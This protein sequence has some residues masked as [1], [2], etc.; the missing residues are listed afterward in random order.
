MRGKTTFHLNMFVWYITWNFVFIVSLGQS[1][2]SEISILKI[3]I[4]LLFQNKTNIE[5]IEL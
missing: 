1:L 4:L 3:E 5:N 2:V